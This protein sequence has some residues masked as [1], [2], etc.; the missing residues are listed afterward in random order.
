MVIFISQASELYLFLLVI[1]IVASA[2][3]IIKIML[4]H[5]GVVYKFAYAEPLNHSVFSHRNMYM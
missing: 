4:L 1:T 2:I 3:L 5:L